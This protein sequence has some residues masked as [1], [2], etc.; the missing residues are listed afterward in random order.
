MAP[1][2]SPETLKGLQPEHFLILRNLGL[3]TDRHAVTYLLPEEIGSLPGSASVLLV[4]PVWREDAADPSPDCFAVDHSSTTDEVECLP[5]HLSERGRQLQA[6]GSGIR[7]VF[8]RSETGRGRLDTVRAAKTPA[9]LPFGFQRVLYWQPE[10]Q[11]FVALKDGDS[12]RFADTLV[13]IPN[14]NQRSV[15]ILPHTEI[16][17]LGGGLAEYR[18]STG[19]RK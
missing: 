11:K 1:A 19:F 9:R 14:N 6:A 2:Y 17:S 4:E 10:S 3:P 12:F 16:A 13:L 5:Y 7:L 8:S 15:Y 18:R